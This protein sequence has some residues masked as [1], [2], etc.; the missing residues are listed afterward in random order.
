MGVPGLE[1]GTSSLSG[2]RSNQLSYTPGRKSSAWYTAILSLAAG[3]SNGL[4]RAFSAAC[5]GRLQQL[6]R[7]HGPKNPAKKVRGSP[8]STARTD[9]RRSVPQN[10]SRSREPGTWRHRFRG[11]RELSSDPAGGNAPHRLPFARPKEPVL[12]ARRPDEPC[13]IAAPRC[14]HFF[15]PGTPRPGGT[16]A[17]ATLPGRN[18]GRCRT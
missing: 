13:P 4:W 11:K 2:M 8:T 17:R 1:P 3:V 9:N 16:P 14:D 6:G 10:A 15:L 18:A 12:T 5:R 7:Q